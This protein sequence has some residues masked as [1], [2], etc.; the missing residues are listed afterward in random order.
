MEKLLKTF[1][2]LSDRNRFRIVSILTTWDELCAC[3][4][5]Q[6]LKISGATA[7]RH[8]QL[9]LISDLICSRKEGRWVYYRLN[10][11]NPY[12]F[13]LLPLITNCIGE[14]QDLQDD[15]KIMENILCSN[16]PNGCS[17]K[18]TIKEQFY[19]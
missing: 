1:Q 17:T 18:L 5:T 9:L 11:D 4:I 15:I 10:R 6:L 16:S 3:Q 13:V 14:Q 19:E 12:S 2:S 7:S 8:L